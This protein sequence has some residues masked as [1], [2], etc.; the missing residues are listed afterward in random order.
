MGQAE[1][2]VFDGLRRLYPNRHVWRLGV[3]LTGTDL[4]DSVRRTAEFKRLVSLPDLVVTTKPPDRTWL[5]RLLAERCQDVPLLLKAAAGWSFDQLGPV[6]MATEVKA[7]GLG[8]YAG[9]PIERYKV[10]RLADVEEEMEACLHAPLFI[11]FTTQTEGE[12]AVCLLTPSTL[13][14]HAIPAYVSWMKADGAL[15]PAPLLLHRPWYSLTE[16]A[17]G[18]GIRGRYVQVDPPRSLVIAHRSSI[19]SEDPPGHRR[20][21]N[22]EDVAHLFPD[23]LVEVASPAPMTPRQMYEYIKRPSFGNVTPMRSF[24]TGERRAQYAHARCEE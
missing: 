4:D 19:E 24:V 1:Q 14:R 10:D 8:D 16:T 3:D 5:G 6:V 17:H 21:V 9:F 13:Q 22:G 7:L 12:H 11:A 18:T 15:I 2:S 20:W 23:D